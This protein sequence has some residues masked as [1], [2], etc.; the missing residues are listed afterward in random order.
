MVTYKTDGTIEKTA[1][2]DAVK[3][4][5]WEIRKFDHVLLDFD[6]Q[7]TMAVTPENH[8]DSDA[9]SYVS[10]TYEDGR[11]TTATATQ[12]A[13]IGCM[14]DENGRNG[15]MIVNATDP[16]SNKSNTVTVQFTDATKAT[17]YINGEATEITLTD[18][19]Y[20]FTLSS[21]QGVFVV[22]DK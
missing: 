5:N 4:M 22:L 13:I 19:S 12:E 16:G 18:G 11:I 17:A 6:W 8:A 7:G 2:Y 3:A 1:T 14:E 21:G 15:Y 20:T 9:F 10:D